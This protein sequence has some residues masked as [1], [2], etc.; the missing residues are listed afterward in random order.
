MS[1]V[2]EINERP[3]F[4]AGKRL[5]AANQLLLRTVER[6]S[7]SIAQYRRDLPGFGT[8][9]PNP[10][11]DTY[12]VV[13]KLSSFEPHDI[14]RDGHHL[15]RPAFRGGS[16]S[17][18]DLRHSW[19][20]DLQ[21]PFH[22]INFFV[23]QHTLDGLAEDLRAP[24]IGRLTCPLDSEQRDDVMLHLALSLRPALERPW[25]ATRLFADQIAAAMSTHL[26]FAYGGL[27]PGGDPI[28]GG[29]S[30]VQERRVKEML[31]ADLRGD[32]SLSD[33]AAACGLSAGHFSR[34]FKRTTGLPPHRW[35]MEQRLKRAKALLLDPSRT[36]SDVAMACGFAD[37]SHFT[38]VFSGRVGATPGA[39]KR[40]MGG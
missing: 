2:A 15:R 26:A 20:T 34:A 1:D 30:P 23:P 5:D 17:I 7:L 39:W 38:R 8:T 16:L 35:L 31:M 13:V 22:T 40:L 28:K 19:T 29:L 27:T 36:V 24:K 11:S 3:F 33:L 37:Q 4:A 18:L 12:M 32:V 9:A 21:Q 14:W 6:G 25:E 10:V